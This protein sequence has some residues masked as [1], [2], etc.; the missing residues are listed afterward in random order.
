MPELRPIAEDEFEAL[1]RMLSTSFGGDADEGSIADERRIFELDR[2]IAAL[3]GGEIVGSAAAYSFELTLPGGTS[4]PVAGVTWVGVLPTHRRQ[5]ILRSMM[6]YQLTDISRRGESLAVLTASEG[7][8]YGRFGY[9]LA[10]FVASS[11]IPT[12]ATAFR[13]EPDA[14]GRIRLVD[15]EAARKLLPEIDEATRFA[16]AGTIKR[17]D[18]WWETYLSD[19][20][21]G[22]YGASGR[23]YAVHQGDGGHPDGFA[24]YRISNTRSRDDAR[25]GNMVL[26]RELRATE[27]EVEAAL[28]RYLLDIDLVS[29]VS[30]LHRPLD[31]PL[32][33][34]LADAFHYRTK[35][36]ND[37]LWVRLVDVPAALAAR[38]YGTEGTIVF[39]VRDPFRPANDGCYELDAGPEGA[40]C[41]RPAGAEADVSLDIDALGAAYLGGVRFTT[42]AAA[43]RAAGDHRAL[44]RADALFASNPLPFCNVGF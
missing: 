21:D 36:V 39:E 35:T 2:S 17:S 24:A 23:F 18:A 44:L 3:D 38:R 33:F 28:C 20:K 1:H 32:R 14:G 15:A 31:D 8:I 11:D 40:T 34:R 19:P 12:H 7:G 26:A 16:R 6:D 9:G 25:P 42:L 22:R 5:G 27:A 4:A 30:L 37:W 29:K 10:T 13:P 41:R 43:R